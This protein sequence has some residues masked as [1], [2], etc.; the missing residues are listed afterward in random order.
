MKKGGWLYRQLAKLIKKAK[1]KIMRK[2][3]VFVVS[4]QNVV[5]CELWVLWKCPC[6][7]NFV[8]ECYDHKPSMR[9]AHFL[10]PSVTFVMNQSLSF[11]HSLP[12]PYHLLLSHQ[13]GLWNSH[14]LVRFCKLQFFCIYIASHQFYCTYILMKGVCH[15]TES[16][17]D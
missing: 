9:P 13:N 17:I 5:S 10:K 15:S 1:N 4:Y 11:L 3:I 8:C 7:S 16:L 12:L 14:S 6:E 2:T